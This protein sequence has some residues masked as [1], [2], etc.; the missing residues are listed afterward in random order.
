MGFYGALWGGNE[1]VSRRGV[2]VCGRMRARVTRIW[3]RACANARGLRM[4]DFCGFR[5]CRGAPGGSENAS[6][7]KGLFVLAEIR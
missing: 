3:V 4:A 7:S 5:G 6:R 2:G 1:G